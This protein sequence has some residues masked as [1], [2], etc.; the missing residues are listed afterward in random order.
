MFRMSFRDGEKFSLAVIISQVVKNKK[1]TE[2][3]LARN[4]GYSIAETTSFC[5]FVSISFVILHSVK[6]TG[7]RRV[8]ARQAERNVLIRYAQKHIFRRAVI[9]LCPVQK[10]STQTVLNSPIKRAVR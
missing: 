7:I 5:L 3:A 4:L 6:E 9:Y 1:I 8:V 2:P 10:N